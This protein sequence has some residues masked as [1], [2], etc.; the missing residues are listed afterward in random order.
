MTDLLPPPPPRAEP[1]PSHPYAL[2]VGDMVRD[3][4]WQASYT[5]PRSLQQAIGP[6]DVGDGC[7]RKLAYRR[8]HTPPV[9]FPDPFRA[10]VGTAVHAYLAD[11]FHA[12]DG[13]TGRFG[14]ELPVSY[15]D[16]AGHADLI[17]RRRHLLIDWKTTT[18]RNRKMRLGGIPPRNHA[19]QITTYAL[20]ARAAGETVDLMALVYLPVDGELSD[21]AVWVSPVTAELI[22]QVDEAID[23]Y[24][25]HAGQPPD[26][27]RA[28]PSALCGWCPWHRPG[29]TN[30]MIACPGEEGT[31]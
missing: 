16:V 26:T 21:V 20:G 31:P 11:I 4:I 18:L 23:S 6:S 8:E 27:V 22:A 3:A 25:A 7:A 14:I 29:S 10:D 5:R 30:L 13:G 19:I 15:R 28:T 1:A 12:L 24:E 2:V 17:D 9:N